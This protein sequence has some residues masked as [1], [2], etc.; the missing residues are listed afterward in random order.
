MKPD[1]A[2]HMLQAK[3]DMQTELDRLRSTAVVLEESSRT[4]GTIKTTYDKY[5]TSLS[6]ASRSLKQLKRRMENDDRMIYYSFIFFMVSAVY[7]FLKRVRVISLVR[8][9]GMTGWIGAEWVYN[10]TSS[11]EDVV[12]IPSTIPVSPYPSTTHVPYMDHPSVTI[13]SPTTTIPP[14]DHGIDL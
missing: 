10:T 5:T 3:R 14:E 11:R 8:W 7:V 12:A 13:F 1:N 2:T 4:I 9:L 6:K